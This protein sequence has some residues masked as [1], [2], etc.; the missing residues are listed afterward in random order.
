MANNDFGVLIV[1]GLAGTA[2]VLMSVFPRLMPRMTNILWALCGMK[3]RLIE[4]D[5][6]KP[7]VRISGVLFII[8]SLY[9][10]I[11]RWPLLRK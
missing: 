9:V 1:S 5:Y 8:F 4:D 10:L 3:S 2:G 7:G 11:E 6:A